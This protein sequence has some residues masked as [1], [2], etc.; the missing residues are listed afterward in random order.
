MADEQRYT[1]DEVRALL[2]DDP[3]LNTIFLYFT[4]NNSPG[5]DQLRALYRQM[6]E[7][8]N[9]E[10]ANFLIILI[11][12][13]IDHFGSPEAFMRDLEGHYR[14]DIAMTKELRDRIKKG[15]GMV[16]GGRYT[17]TRFGGV[18]SRGSKYVFI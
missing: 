2:N 6:E 16:K 4:G 15:E 8:G 11:R 5:A 10:S 12:Q 1:I 13:M 7:E 9:V 18:K 17:G 14:R 3:D